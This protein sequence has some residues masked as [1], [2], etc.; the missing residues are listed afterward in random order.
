[1]ELD[2]LKAGW[3][4]LDRRVA[5]LELIAPSRGAAAG[6]HA[7]LRPLA[8]GQALQMMFGV[9]VAMVTGFFWVDHRDAA[10]LLV[11]GLLLH[12]YGIAMI[13]TAA[14]NLVL[15]ARTSEAQPVLALQQRVAALRAWRIRE[16]RW[17]GVLGCFIWV[18]MIIGAFGLL[19]IDLVT[20]CPWFVALNLL[21]S[22]AF[23]GAY[24][25]VSRL[26]KVPEGRAVRRAQERLDEVA[27]FAGGNAV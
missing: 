27:R 25:T 19:G 17:F 12:G 2:D 23:L 14:R 20:A 10:G 1:M 26:V 5:A 18:P 16:G 7:E 8:W 9:L 22:C 21:V 3:V 11:A 6:V 15:V 4:E 13:V 24:V